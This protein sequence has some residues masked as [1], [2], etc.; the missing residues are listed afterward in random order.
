MRYVDMAACRTVVFPVLLLLLLATMSNVAAQSSLKGSDDASVTRLPAGPM[1]EIVTPEPG[2]GWCLKDT[3][4]ITWNSADVANV[5]IELSSNGGGTWTWLA[6]RPASTRTFA[7]KI[8]SSRAPGADYRI[9]IRDV[10][11]ILIAD[12]VDGSFTIATPPLATITASDL[13]VPTFSNVSIASHSTGSPPSTIQWEKSIDDLDYT[14]IPGERSSVLTLRSVT[15]ARDA[16]Y[17]RVVYGNHC[18]S[19]TSGAVLLTITKATAQID[20]DDLYQIYNGSPRAATATTFPPGL[21]VDIGYWRNGASVSAPTEVGSYDVV[22]TIVDSNYTGMAEAILVI[23]DNTEVQERESGRPNT[24]S[25]W[26]VPNPLRGDGEI[27]LE[28]LAPG[29][30]RATIHD[31]IGRP[32]ESIET[33]VTG[34]GRFVLPI[35]TDGLA[36]GIYTVRITTARGVII[37]PMRLLR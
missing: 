17:Y 24:I 12:T 34:S 4:P 25:G 18:G 26:V 32:L 16:R 29:A 31:M 9:R 35:E 13:V 8:P 6:S 27:H 23:D 10:G 19:S 36:S 33:I 1:I 28:G 14:P 37:L 2:S 22:A 15:S 7:W 3:I 11:N 30:L 21:T 20:L 5:W